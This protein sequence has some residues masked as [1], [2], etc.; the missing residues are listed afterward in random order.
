M[1]RVPSVNPNTNIHRDVDR[2]AFGRLICLLTVGLICAGGFLL[3]ARQHVMAIRLG[4]QTEALRHEKEKL[5]TDESQLKVDLVRATNPA[6]IAS[7]GEKLGLQSTTGKQLDDGSV[8][9]SEPSRATA[10]KAPITRASSVK[11]SATGKPV[12]NKKLADTKKPVA[13][14]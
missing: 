4:Y 13:K 8:A 5:K 2:A 6:R 1:R 12:E 14:H 7:E 3:A 9:E 10:S 11:G